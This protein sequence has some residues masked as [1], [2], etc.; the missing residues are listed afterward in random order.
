MVLR[1][2]VNCLQWIIQ[3]V[4][5]H[6]LMKKNG[7]GDV[8]AA[9][10]CCQAKMKTKA[11]SR[12]LCCLPSLPC[13]NSQE[14]LDHL[15][16]KELCTLAGNSRNKREGTVSYRSYLGILEH[17]QIHNFCYSTF[18]L[19]WCPKAPVGLAHVAW[20]A[21]QHL[22]PKPLRLRVTG[23]HDGCAHQQLV[24]PALSAAV[25]FQPSS[26]IMR[27]LTDFKLAPEKFRSSWWLRGWNYH[28]RFLTALCDVISWTWHAAHQLNWPR[29]SLA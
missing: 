23:E 4:K 10:M 26:R 5:V 3:S 7:K 11:R 8:L 17:A 18:R 20:G 29:P 9:A 14:S 25:K 2:L 13:I 16:A 1:G 22:P 6:L 21:A 24:R 15:K 12:A 27:T 28:N 19:R